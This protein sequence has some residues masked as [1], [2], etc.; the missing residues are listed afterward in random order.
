MKVDQSKLGSK[1][2]AGQMNSVVCWLHVGKMED[3]TSERKAT[4]GQ[5]TK[6]KAF[7]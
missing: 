2:Q 6:R 3:K 5:R 7:A 1:Q 4:K